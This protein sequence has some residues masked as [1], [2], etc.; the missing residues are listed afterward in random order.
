MNRRDAILGL[1]L[2]AGLPIPLLSCSSK[3]PPPPPPPPSTIVKVEF[4][5]TDGV[6]PDGNGTPQ[7][8]HVRILRLSGMESL[9]RTDFFTLEADEKKALGSDLV[10]ADRLVLV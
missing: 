8:V 6:N 5:A 9:A 10:G 3:P 2:S 7:P 1:S 4:Q